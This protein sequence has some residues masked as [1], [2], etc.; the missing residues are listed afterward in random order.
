M[1]E[2]TAALEAENVRLLKKK[3]E[4]LETENS[5]LK[6][7]KKKLGVPRELSVCFLLRPSH[8]AKVYLEHLKIHVSLCIKKNSLFYNCLVKM[9]CSEHL[10][11][12]MSRSLMDE[13]QSASCFIFS[14]LVECD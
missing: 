13:Q 10:K 11:M 5:K 14:Y 12:E 1:E 6:K 4:A 8:V 7:T 9:P 2:K 3:N